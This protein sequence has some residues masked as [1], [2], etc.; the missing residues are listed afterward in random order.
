MA[1]RYHEINRNQYSNVHLGKVEADYNPASEEFLQ[2]LIE[3][4][5]LFL[6]LPNAVVIIFS[7]FY[8]LLNKSFHL[9]IPCVLV[10]G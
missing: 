8:C 2:L 5:Y 1:V 9:I 10:F 4:L 7:L 3:V 6:A